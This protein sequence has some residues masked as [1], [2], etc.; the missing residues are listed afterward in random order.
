M[1]HVRPIM[2]TSMLALTRSLGEPSSVADLI[3]WPGVDHCVP[4]ERNPLGG[5]AILVVLLFVGNSENVDRLGGALLTEGLFCWF[6]NWN[7]FTWKW[8]LCQQSIP[9]IKHDLAW[10]CLSRGGRDFNAEKS[11]KPSIGER[12]SCVGQF[13][14]AQCS[15]LYFIMILL[16]R[17]FLDVLTAH[18][19]C[20]RK[21]TQSCR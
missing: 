2:W 5:A 18:T 15:F 13:P 14:T 3:R 21:G 8:H 10:P 7:E 9:A 17:S 16:H 6:Q 11:G 20:C 19:V 4:A 12:G 1:S